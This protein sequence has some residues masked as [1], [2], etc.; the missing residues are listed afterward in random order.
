M[1]PTTTTL[2]TSACDECGTELHLIG[3]GQPRYWSCRYCGT[4]SPADR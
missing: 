4:A 1:A 3:T 2:S